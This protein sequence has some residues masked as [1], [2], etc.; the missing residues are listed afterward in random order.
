[1]AKPNQKQVEIMRH[2]L[3]CSHKPG[4]RNN[5]CAHICDP[6]MVQAV[7]SGWMLQRNVFP[8]GSAYFSVT[9][10]GAKAIGLD[11]AIIRTKEAPRK[12]VKR[13]TPME[14]PQDG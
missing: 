6:L 14:T 12:H 7:K 8:D 11:P 4:W 3:G 1:M 2:A 9:R 13:A 10:K 5:Y